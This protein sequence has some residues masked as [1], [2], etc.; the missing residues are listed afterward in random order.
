MSKVENKDIEDLKKC[1]TVSDM[2]KLLESR[3]DLNIKPGPMVRS[4]FVQGLTDALIMLKPAR[5]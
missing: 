4:M 3:F 2:L 1:E 5:K